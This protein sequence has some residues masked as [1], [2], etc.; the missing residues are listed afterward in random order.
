MAP[1]VP[2]NDREKKHIWVMC[3]VVC[4]IDANE[5]AVHEVLERVHL[6]RGLH[7]QNK[8]VPLQLGSRG[9]RSE[10]VFVKDINFHFL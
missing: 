2:S 4:G 7:T 10:F 6:E 3:Y 9:R 1:S 5:A 8:G